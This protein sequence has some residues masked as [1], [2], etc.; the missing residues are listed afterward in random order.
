M[1]DRPSDDLSPETQDETMPEFS[2]RLAQDGKELMDKLFPLDQFPDDEAGKNFLKLNKDFFQTSAIATLKDLDP[3]ERVVF[4]EKVSDI[5]DV[6]LAALDKI[7]LAEGER[8]EIIGY[9]ESLTPEDLLSQRT[10]ASKLNINNPQNATYKFRRS[11][12]QSFLV[13]REVSLANAYLKMI[14]K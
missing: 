1:I 13:N 11:L 5:R 8:E 3:E 12:A 7:E 9:I 10:I 4:L 6:A 14:D 2:V